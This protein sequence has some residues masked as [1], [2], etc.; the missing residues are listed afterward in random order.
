DP[1]DRVPPPRPPWAAL[2]AAAAVP[3]GTLGFFVG[4]W[5]AGHPFTVSLDQQGE[6]GRENVGPLS[7]IL[8]SVEAAGDG[9]SA[10]ASG[11]ITS[12]GLE[13]MNPLLLLFLVVG[14]VALVG[15]ARRLPPAYA[16]YAGAALLMPLSSPAVGGGEPLMSLPRFLGVLFP[17]AMWAGWWL[18]HGRHE[19]LRRWTLG[20]A[21][22]GLLVLFS[23]LTA[24]WTFVA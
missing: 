14:I 18:T 23:A 16:A 5:A 10:L 9:I 24:R 1:R 19:R 20:V 17:L 6:W 8:R 15:A 12:A 21:G 22:L 3:L 2:A 4:L 11:G 13:W 7:G